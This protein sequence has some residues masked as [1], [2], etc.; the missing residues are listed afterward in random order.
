MID[1]H[2]AIF[3]AIKI[4]PWYVQCILRALDWA[5]ALLF[6][7]DVFGARIISLVDLDVLMVDE[8]C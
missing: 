4:D 8:S 7:T 3:E 5:L 6:P 2:R 1:D